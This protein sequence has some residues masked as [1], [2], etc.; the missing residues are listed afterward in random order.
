MPKRSQNG[1]KKSCKTSCL[2]CTFLSICK[3]LL[4]KKRKK[5][6]KKENCC[7]SR[8]IFTLEMKCFLIFVKVFCA[9]FVPKITIRE[10]FC[11]K[12]RD[13]LISRKFLLAKVSAPEVYQLPFPCL[14]LIRT[15][16]FR[17]HSEL[18]LNNC[19]RVLLFFNVQLKVKGKKKII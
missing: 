16:A 2:A 3:L 17:T 11:Q 6:K 15:I 19:Y 12:F 5:K 18:K 9:K 14:W 7:H 10:S 4:D 13:F 8:K 1:R